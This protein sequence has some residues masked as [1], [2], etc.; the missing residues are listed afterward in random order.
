LCAH[1]ISFRITSHRN[2]MNILDSIPYNP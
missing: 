2:V 1:N